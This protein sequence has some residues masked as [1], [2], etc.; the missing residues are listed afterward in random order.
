MIN[1][2]KAS[3]FVD[4]FSFSVQQKRQVSQKFPFIISGMEE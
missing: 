1:E 3:T 4:A 2:W